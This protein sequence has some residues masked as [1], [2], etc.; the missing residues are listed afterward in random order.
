[1]R[2]AALVGVAIGQAEARK[3][4]KAERQ[5]ILDGLERRVPHL[6]G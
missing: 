5:A 6:R 2:R 3:A 1:L 4:T